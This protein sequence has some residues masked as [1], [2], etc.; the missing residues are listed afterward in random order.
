MP[1]TVIRK[2]AHHNFGNHL[3]QFLK[4]LCSIICFL[5]NLPELLFPDTRQF[6][7]L[8]Q[9]FMDNLNKFDACRCSNQVFLFLADIIALEQS[10]NN[11]RTRRRPADTILFQSIPQFIVIHQ[12]TCGFHGTQQGSLC[13]RTRRL[14]PLLI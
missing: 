3:F 4:K 8:Q 5:F 10:L 1:V 6:G 13:I 12:F 14:R 2:H 11:C 9:F 7:R